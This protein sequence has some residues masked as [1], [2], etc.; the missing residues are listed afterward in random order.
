[1][2]TTAYEACPECGFENTL[3]V[4]L[5]KDGYQTKCAECGADLMLCDECLHL[6]DGTRV[7]VCDFRW[8]DQARGVGI[9]F[10]REEA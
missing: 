9:C 4:D 6:S 1:M 7:N 10:R 2:K 8:I 3:L 5:E